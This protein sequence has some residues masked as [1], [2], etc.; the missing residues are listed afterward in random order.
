MT[1]KISYKHK[2]C[3]LLWLGGLTQTKAMLEVGYKPTVAHKKTD[4]VFSRPDVKAFIAEEQNKVLTKLGVTKEWMTTQLVAVAQTG[5]VLAK[6]IKVEPTSGEVFWDFRGATEGE[7]AL[8]DSL[9]V[10]TSYGL[11][12]KKVKCKITMPSRLAALEA[13]CRIYGLN[14]DPLADALKM[15]LVER[16]QAGRK[17]ASGKGKE[18]GDQS[19]DT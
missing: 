14:K 2:C 9:T 5:E 4:F 15:S 16:L 19:D 8:I 13:L 7:L 12:G 10:D 3:A 6:F 11:G 18:D 1:K 17:R